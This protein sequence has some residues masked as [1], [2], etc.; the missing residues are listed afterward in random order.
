[1]IFLQTRPSVQAALKEPAWLWAFLVFAAFTAGLFEEG[2]RWLAFRFLI[3]PAERQWRTALML[4]AGH[5]GLE[6][7][8]VG[9]VALAALAGYLAVTLL[10]PDTFGGAVPQVEQAR[11]QFASMRGWEPLLGAWERLGALAIQVALTVLVLQAFLRGRRWWWYALGAHTLVDFT[12][13]GLVALAG[14]AWGQ[15]AAML[16]AEGLVGV[17]AVLGLWLI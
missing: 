7:V 13:V 15:Q 9:L 4:G 6:S 17:Y 16:L 1:M 10:P 12:T 14:K 8:C 11:E 3:P 2:G 5:G